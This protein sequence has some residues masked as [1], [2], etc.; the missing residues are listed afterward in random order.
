MNCENVKQKRNR[1]EEGKT[2]IKPGG[3]GKKF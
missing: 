3:E 2:G 1:K